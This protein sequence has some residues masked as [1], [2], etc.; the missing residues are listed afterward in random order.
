[1]QCNAMQCNAMKQL[2]VIQD[3]KKMLKHVTYHMSHDTCHVPS[4]TF[5]LQGGGASRG[6]VCY[7]RGLPRLVLRL[8]ALSFNVWAWRRCEVLFRK[9]VTYLVNELMENIVCRVAPG[10]A[11]V[12]Q[13]CVP[14]NTSCLPACCTTWT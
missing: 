6:R 8:L 11:R 2:D 14:E 3:T 12:C 1:M 7:Q 9:G 5:F 13:I 10:F 4:V